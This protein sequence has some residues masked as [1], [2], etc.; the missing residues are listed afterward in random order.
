M[1]NNYHS[2]PD[3]QR[4]KIPFIEFWLFI[5]SELGS[6][7]L[8]LNSHAESIHQVLD[9]GSDH[10]HYLKNIITQS[11]KRSRC[12][13]LRAPININH[14]LDVLGET[15]Y[16]LQGKRCDDLMDIELLEEIAWHIGERYER[17]LNIP[18]QNHTKDDRKAEV[19]SLPNA[20][21]RRANIRL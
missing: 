9:K 5:G 21:I 4:L 8:K 19:L 10:Q 3:S 13:H 7:R 2:N 17:H 20:K 1:T 15:A 14:V 12:N 16:E 11:Y 18:T 6:S